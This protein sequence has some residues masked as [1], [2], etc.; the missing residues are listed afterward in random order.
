MWPLLR[1]GY[2]VKFKKVDPETL[3][4]GDVLVLRG[5]DRRGRSIVQVHRLLDRV[6]PFFLEAGDNGFSASLVSADAIL[7][8]VTEARDRA[9]RPI[10][11][12]R[13]SPDMM[14]VRFRFFRGLAHAFV[15]AHEMKDRAMGGV[16]SPLLW[17]ASVAYRKGL[18]LVGVKVPVIFPR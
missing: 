12:A 4:P 11:V 14:S 16:K 6:G 1:T 9:H 2:R 3:E 15:Y 17:K 7:G 10:A 5:E 8:L 18:S 13:V